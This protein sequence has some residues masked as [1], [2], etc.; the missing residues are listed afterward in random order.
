[1]LSRRCRWPR[2][3]RSNRH[4]FPRARPGFHRPGR[5]SSRPT[6]SAGMASP[7]T[8]RTSEADSSVAAQSPFHCAADRRHGLCRVAPVLRR[9][10]LG[11]PCLARGVGAPRRCGRCRVH[12]ASVSQLPRAGYRCRA[13]FA[14]SWPSR[15]RHH[16][17][18]TSTPW[19]VGVA[20][21][22][23]RHLRRPAHEY[24]PGVRRPPAASS[25]AAAY[26]LAE[27]TRADSFPQMQPLRC[28]YRRGRTGLHGWL[29]RNN[30]MASRSAVSNCGWPLERFTLLLRTTPS[31]LIEN[32]AVDVPSSAPCSQ[33]R[34]VSQSEQGAPSP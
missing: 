28:G 29:G 22:A 18:E 7:A 34:T 23:R 26:A 5:T 11:R 6:T 8:H 2:S 1:M 4:P 15:A 30:L 12:R 13:H 32:S 9:S 3:H 33:T 19:Y 21:G 31:A 14:T 24:H 17:G 27:S 25:R 16:G 10:W 20:P